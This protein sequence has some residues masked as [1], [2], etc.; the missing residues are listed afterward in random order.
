MHSVQFVPAFLVL[1]SVIAQ[2]LPPLRDHLLI[3]DTGVGH[4]SSPVQTW[5]TSLR[6]LESD[7]SSTRTLFEY[8]NP[9]PQNQPIGSTSIV[10]DPETLSVYVATGQ[11]IIRTEIDGSGNETVIPESATSVVLAGGRLYWGTMYDGLIKS[12]NLDGTDVKMA[13]NVSS[14]INYNIIPSY[15]PAISYPDGLAVVP[16]DFMYWSSSNSGIGQVENGTIKRISI[17]LSK[18]MKYEEIL[19]TSV[20]MPGQLRVVGPWLYFVEKGRYSNSPTSLKR[21][22]IPLARNRDPVAIETII[23]ASQFPEIFTEN[24]KVDKLTL[25]IKSFAVD[26]ENKRLWVAAESNS[27][28]MFAKIIEMGL[29]GED[30]KVIN[31]DPKQ[32]GIPVGLEY[33]R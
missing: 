12:A 4:R 10:L 16:R 29:D 2:K 19:V 1:A 26:T 18:E 28:I 22:K 14:G 6:R 31:S 27:R 5:Q 30:V 23:S 25:S 13:R 33:V 15:T 8:G 7:G 17:S 32:I 24:D 9:T 11:G 20:N 21:F 3:A